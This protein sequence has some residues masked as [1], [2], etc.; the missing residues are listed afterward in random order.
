MSVAR[1]EQC[2]F[3]LI[4]ALFV[5][6]VLAAL[7]AF[8]VRINMTQEHDAQLELQELRARAALDAGVEYAAARLLVSAANNCG[9]LANLNNFV[10]NFA[11][12]F[13]G[14][15][16]TQYVVN[17]VTLNVYTVNVTS[18]HGVYGTP[19]FVARQALGVRIAG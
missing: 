17:G 3:A 9:T 6:V 14:C 19:E 13:N 4:G 5:I 18:T 15:V 2:G 1:R 10:G 16:R 7:G 12:T 11:V 8:A